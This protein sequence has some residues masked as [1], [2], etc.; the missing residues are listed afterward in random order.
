M[1]WKKIFTWCGDNLSGI[2][3]VFAILISSVSLLVTYSELSFHKDRETYAFWTHINSDMEEQRRATSRAYE[4]MMRDEGVAYAILGTI[5]DER[6]DCKALT[7]VMARAHEY[8]VSE[9]ATVESSDESALIAE[10]RAT[11]LENRPLI[12]MLH[13]AGWSRFVKAERFSD[14]WWGSVAWN[15]MHIQFLSGIW[16]WRCATKSIQAIR[17]SKLNVRLLKQALAITRKSA[18]DIELYGGPNIM[19]IQNLE[20]ENES[21]RVSIWNIRKKL[22]RVVG[23]SAHRPKSLHN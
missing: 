3:S 2:V 10:Y 6:L 11:V 1:T 13:I 4:R 22:G 8:G 18:I 5:H 14:K 9:T 23:D 7:K 19:A 20:S 21:A 15:A 12:N 16:G 17:V